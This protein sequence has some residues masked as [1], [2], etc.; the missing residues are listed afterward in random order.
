M[1]DR[2]SVA[3]SAQHPSHIF[4]AIVPGSKQSVAI[5]ASSASSTELNSKTSIIR[6]FPT[7]DCF[8]EFG[9]SPTATTSSHFCPGGVIQYFGVYQ[10]SKLA[11]IR[12]STSGTLYIMEGV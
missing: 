5:G 2:A 4:Q 11:V 12:S 3:P 9:D 6:I 7:V 10:F 8:I 1:S